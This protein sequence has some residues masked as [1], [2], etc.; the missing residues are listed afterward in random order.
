[1][2]KELLWH[3]KNKNR[4]A[5]EEEMFIKDVEKKIISILLQLDGLETIIL[6][7]FFFVLLMLLFELHWY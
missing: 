5:T 6:S 4:L 2:A 7:I 3:I 1:M